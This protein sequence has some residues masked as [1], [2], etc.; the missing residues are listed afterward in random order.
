MSIIHIKAAP[1]RHQSTNDHESMLIAPVAKPRGIP[2]I[3][4]KPTIKEGAIAISGLAAREKTTII[5]KRPI[6]KI[7]LMIKPISKACGGKRNSPVLGKITA[8]LR[9]SKIIRYEKEE[10]I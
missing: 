6:K 5:N 2:N 7:G 1:A 4:P 10:I 8:K 9:E 3:S